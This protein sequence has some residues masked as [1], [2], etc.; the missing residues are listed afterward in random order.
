MKTNLLLALLFCS[1][2]YTQDKLAT[3]PDLTENERHIQTHEKMAKAHQQAADC[4]KSGKS[5]SDCRQ[6]F[7]DEC[8]HFAGDGRCNGWMNRRGMRHWEK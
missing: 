2:A 3:S 1:A 8:K 4:L 5:T 7:Q 6:Q